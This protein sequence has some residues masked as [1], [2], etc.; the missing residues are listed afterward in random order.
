M[1]H[2]HKYPECEAY[3][4]TVVLML[5]CQIEEKASKRHAQIFRAALRILPRQKRPAGFH[6][7]ECQSWAVSSNSTI[8]KKR[9]LFNTAFLL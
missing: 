9:D 3:R 8:Y 4:S 5:L 1:T 2:I 6:H 7:A